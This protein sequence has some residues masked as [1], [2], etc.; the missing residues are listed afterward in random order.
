ME[1]KPEQTQS[2]P[3][4][5]VRLNRQKL[6]ILLVVIAVIVAT[7]VALRNM[8]LA[9]S[10]GEAPPP[11]PAVNLSSPTF[12]VVYDTGPGA[13]RSSASFKVANATPGSDGKDFRVT[14][15]TGNSWSAPVPLKGDQC[16]IA[17]SGMT[18][19]IAWCKWIEVPG[20]E[21][22]EWWKHWGRGSNVTAGDSIELNPVESVI[23]YLGR[24]ALAVL[25]SDGST[26]ANTSFL[27]PTAWPLT[28]W[29]NYV[30]GAAFQLLAAYP[31][32]HPSDVR[33]SVSVGGESSGLAALPSE[34]QTPVNLTTGSLNATVE[35]V[36][37]T[38]AGYV[39]PMDVFVIKFP[40]EATPSQLTLTFYEAD[41]TELGSGIWP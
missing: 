27:W 36:N 11:K 40:N 35:W 2:A 34:P 15:W 3:P 5:R 29:D 38:T 6:A 19:Y 32:L 1:T 22:L 4:K 39:E 8:T 37:H 16:E 28:P 13:Y 23:P 24:V 17:G 7:G 30:G 21:I 41:G 18:Y 12:K 9:N 20:G 14:V 25:W 26:V 31:L 33:V 10:P